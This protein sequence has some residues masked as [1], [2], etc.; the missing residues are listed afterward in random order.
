MRTPMVA[1]AA[2]ALAACAKTS[3]PPADTTASSSAMMPAANTADAK[4]AIAKLRDDWIAAAN[5]KDAA[6]VAGVYTD[7]AVFVSTESPVAKGRTA[8]Q[9]AFAKSF[10]VSSNLRVNSEKTE[11]SGDIGYDYGTY[12]WYVTPPKGKAGDVSG[13]YLVTFKR[14]SDGS[15]KISEHVSTTPPKA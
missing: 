11:I 5:K 7:D 2:I 12:T 8:I 10:P 4:A 6:T 14:Q 3:T 15:W 1:L 9:A 13:N